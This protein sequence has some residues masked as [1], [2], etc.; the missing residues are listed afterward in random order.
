MGL[1][2]EIKNSYNN[3]ERTNISNINLRTIELY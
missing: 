2:L 3:I 1:V